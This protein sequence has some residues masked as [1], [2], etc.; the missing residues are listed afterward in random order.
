MAQQQCGSVAMGTSDC[1]RE[2]C[3]QRCGVEGLAVRPG[4]CSRAMPR[5]AQVQKASVTRARLHAGPWEL[6]W[7]WEIPRAM[8]ATA[9]IPP[10]AVLT[11]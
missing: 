1:P 11:M 8:G 9:H 5:A 3:E 6:P 10:T 4:N 7:R 2:G